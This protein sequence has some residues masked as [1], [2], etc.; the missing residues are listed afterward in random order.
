[1]KQEIGKPSS[2]WLQLKRTLASSGSKK[3]VRREESPSQKSHTRSQT[4]LPLDHSLTSGLSTIAG[5]EMKNGEFLGHLRDMVLGKL[6]Y[7]APKSVFLTSDVVTA[8]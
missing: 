1:M 6:K 5:G 8:N 3:R 2:N 4:T 7:D